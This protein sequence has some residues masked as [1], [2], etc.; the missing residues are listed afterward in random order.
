MFQREEEEKGIGIMKGGRMAES[1]V[2]EK[3]KKVMK[4]R[5]E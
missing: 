5:R 4:E 3:K 2:Q 1:T